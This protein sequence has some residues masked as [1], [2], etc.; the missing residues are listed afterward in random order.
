MTP[1]FVTFEGGEGAGK[2]TQ[3]KL[4]AQSFASAAI[5]VDVTREPGG[6][7]GGEIIRKLVVEAGAHQWNAST[8]ALLFMAA[9]YD[10][11][12]TR[13]LPALARGQWV[14]CDRFYDSTYVYQGIAKQVGT[15]W[16]NQLY[17]LLYGTI[18]PDLTILLDIEPE[19]G[20]QRAKSRSGSE[21]RFENLDTAFHYAVR[22]GFL[23]RA[24]SES[25]RFHVVS[26]AQD[27]HQIHAAIVEHVNARFGLALTPSQSSAL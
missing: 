6:S 2:S 5:A 1:R 27:I 4:L 3:I 25:S 18:A 14:L 10:H 17:T 12:H 8:E 9:R 15:E 11:L 23:D 7:Q 22:Q 19:I 16:L 20:L 13:I 21:T 24:T 26:A